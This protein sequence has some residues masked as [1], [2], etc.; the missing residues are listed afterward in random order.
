MNRK[1]M[2]PVLAA[3]VLCA[4]QVRTPDA[5]YDLVIRNGMIYDGSGSAPVKGDV[6]IRGRRIAAIGQI[7]RAHV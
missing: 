3:L 4:C 2:L 5:G 6:A 7:G 1:F